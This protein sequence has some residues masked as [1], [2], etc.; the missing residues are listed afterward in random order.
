MNGSSHLLSPELINRLGNLQ[1]KARMAAEGAMTGLHRSP[2]HGSSIE[3]AEH[4]EYTP[5]DDPRHIDWKAF[6]RLDR[7][8]IKVF[9][10]ETNLRAWLLLDCS[11]SM[12]YASGEESK[13]DYAKVLA[14]ACAYLLLRQQDSA[15]LL[16]FGDTLDPHIPPRST[17][18]HFNEITEALVRKEASGKT[19][20]VKALDWLAGSLTGR[21]IVI[22]LSD[23]LDVREDVLKLLKQIR[24]RKNDVAVLQ[25][26]DPH[27]VDFPFE[28]L[29]EFVDMEGE[30]IVFADPDGIRAEYL[31]LFSEYCDG[32][33]RECLRNGM[34]YRKI[35][36]SMPH[37]EALLGFLRAREGRK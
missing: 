20:I 22:L 28:R 21:S 31:R 19:D 16:T 11:K 17:W 35:V 27:E 4:R 32:I 10:D 8:Y 26:L 29:T 33:G 3:F 6:A 7:F 34:V 13:F 12:A 5:G 2:H 30:R 24:S 36:T 37:H 15:G 14:A 25:I 18:T 9:E 1:L 23:M